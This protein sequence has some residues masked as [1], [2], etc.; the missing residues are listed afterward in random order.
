MKSLRRF[1]PLRQNSADVQGRAFWGLLRERACST[2]TQAG[3]V[4][5]EASSK[6]GCCYADADPIQALGSS[7]HPAPALAPMLLQELH[8]GDH[9]AAV[10]GLT[11][12]VDG[13]QRHLHGGQGSDTNQQ[14]SPIRR[15]PLTRFL[16][17]W[18]DK[19]GTNS[20]VHC[21]CTSHTE[22]V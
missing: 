10:S 3:P 2:L 19:I 8:I 6:S 11:H 14:L 5:G 17:G 4:E 15:L 13:E 21:Q 9:H 1:E 20:L 16:P 18:W 12:V 7:S 22:F